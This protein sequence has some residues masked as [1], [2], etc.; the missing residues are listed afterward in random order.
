MIFFFFKHIIHQNISFTFFVPKV[1]YTINNNPITNT[2]CVN[3][4]WVL[5]CSVS[6]LV[7]GFTNVFPAKPV[8]EERQEIMFIHGCLFRNTVWATN[9]QH[10]SDYD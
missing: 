2:I 7:F 5:E 10:M 6:R 9:T 4:N 3:N 8:K 1:K